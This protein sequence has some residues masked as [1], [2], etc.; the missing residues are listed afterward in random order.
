MSNRKSVFTLTAGAMLLGLVTVASAFVG[1]PQR[2]T[3]LT[4]GAPVAL[5]RVALGAGTY[6]FELAEPGVPDVVRVM[7]ADHTQVYFMGFTRTVDRPRGLSNDVGVT[8]G[9]SSRGLAAPIKAWYPTG[10]S[11]GHEFIY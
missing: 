6:I 4:F 2:T 10:E 5:P 11:I 3:K 7:N 9:E 1:N 8:F